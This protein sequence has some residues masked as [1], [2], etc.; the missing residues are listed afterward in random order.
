MVFGRKEVRLF[1]WYPS[2]IL[3]KQYAKHRIRPIRMVVT[4][5]R[6]FVGS[7]GLLF[8]ICLNICNAAL[9]HSSLYGPRDGYERW[10]IISFN[11]VLP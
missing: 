4:N 8:I 1:W 11:D 2:L 10:M 3:T 5:K 7:Q 9:T 6:T